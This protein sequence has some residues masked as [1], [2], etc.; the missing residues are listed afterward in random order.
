MTI[1]T[2]E[3]A[4]STECGAGTI[5]SPGVGDPVTAGLA[6]GALAGYCYVYF[7]APDGRPENDQKVYFAFSRDGLHWNGPISDMTICSTISERAVRDP[8]L[9][10]RSDRDGFVLIG[11]DLDFNAPWYAKPDGGIDFA[12]TVRRGSTGI[13]VWE[14][15]DLVHW[16]NERVVDVASCVGAGNAW[17]PRAIWDGSRGEYLVYWSSCTKADD[18]GRQRIWAAW[19]RDFTAFGEPFVLIERDHSVIDAALSVCGGR[20]VMYI[21]NEDEKYVYVETADDLLGPYSRLSNPTL[22]RF[23]GGFEGPTSCV[24]P[25]GR[26]LLMTDEYL[27]RWVGYR[28]FVSDDPLAEDSFRALGPQEFSLPAGANHGSIVALDARQW[29]MV[30]DGRWNRKG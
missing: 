20:I 1:S 16:S 25:D 10:R 27:P 14:S 26:I 13:C 24:L 21:K 30:N 9:M 2:V 15:P 3:A 29:A 22:E 5:A 28:P 6:P 19:T 17:A 7:A 12:A 11:T 4:D 18:Y 8:F 23:P